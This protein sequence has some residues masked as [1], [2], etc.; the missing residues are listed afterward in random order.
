MYKFSHVHKTIIA[1]SMIP[2]TPN[3]IVSSQYSDDLIFNQTE[4]KNKTGNLPNCL[5]SSIFRHEHYKWLCSDP[6]KLN[7]V[8]RAQSLLSVT[9]RLFALCGLLLLEMRKQ[10]LY[11]VPMTIPIVHKV[12]FVFFLWM[13]FL[14][15]LRKL[16][17]RR[18]PAFLSKYALSSR[19]RF[20]RVRQLSE[21]FYN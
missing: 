1:T 4:Y 3:S 19:P 6:C 21:E 2:G 18:F 7:K 15:E 9:Y 17:K 20:Y 12:L 14:V 16:S 11:W 13:W 5:F 10:S 8:S